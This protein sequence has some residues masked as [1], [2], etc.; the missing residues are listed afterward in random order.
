[1]PGRPV[2]R[3]SGVLCGPVGYRRRMGWTR[4]SVAGTAGAAAVVLALTGC[5]FLGRFSSAG[6]AS[7]GVSASAAASDAPDA[8]GDPATPT[9]APSA[10]DGTTMVE[11]RRA[12]IRFAVPDSWEIVDFT[13]LLEQADAAEL[14][15]VAEG[16]NLTAAQFRAAASNT[17]LG[18]FGPPSAGFAPNVNVQLAPVEEVPSAAEMRRGLTMVGADVQD[19]QDVTTPLGPGRVT[20][21]RLGV[22][23]TTA[24][25]RQLAV[26]GPGGVALV[27]VSHGDAEQ[28]ERVEAVLRA[29]L[30]VA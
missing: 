10:P 4:R 26:R 5:G 28:A 14:E 29:S 25:G 12:G 8:S 27:T 16:M 13:E 3:E 23:G 22:D 30:A 1:M 21:Y 18:A 11:A 20:I 2:R 7:P 15:A 9:T 19:V 6:P 24:Y 17:D